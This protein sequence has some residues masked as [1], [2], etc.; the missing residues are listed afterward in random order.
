MFVVMTSYIIGQ[1][2]YCA[3]Q[4]NKQILTQEWTNKGRATRNYLFLVRNYLKY[5]S[6]QF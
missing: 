3:L 5:K 2:V 1:R 4:Q 6:D